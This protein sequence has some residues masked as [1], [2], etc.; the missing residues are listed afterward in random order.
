MEF[1]TFGPFDGR[2]ARNRAF[3]AHVLARDGTWRWQRLNDP[4]NFVLWRASW[5][6]FAASMVMLEIASPGALQQYEGGIERLASLYP[7][8]W[9]SIAQLDEEMR[10]EHWNNLY[11][12]LCVRPE[13][14]P[15]DWEPTNKFAGTTWGYII[16]STRSSTLAG[17][18]ADWWR[19]RETILDRAR[20]HRPSKGGDRLAPPVFPSFHGARVIPEIASQASSSSTRQQFVDEAPRDGN[21]NPRKTKKDKPKPRPTPAPSQKGPCHYCGKMGHLQKDCHKKQ[22]DE[23]RQKNQQKKENQQRQQDGGGKKTKKTKP[24]SP[25]NEGLRA[26]PAMGAHWRAL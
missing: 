17:P 13:M 4:S 10:Y 9:A 7:D 6:V 3:N 5:R 26:V 21:P 19:D 11:A 8:D 15:A 1:A 23:N 25:I 2:A 18:R 24:N 14:R 12:Q 22:A 16:S 20:Q